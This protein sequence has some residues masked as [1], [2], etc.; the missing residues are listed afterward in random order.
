[1][2]NILEV[3]EDA[4]TRWLPWTPMWGYGIFIAISEWNV[5][6]GPRL[7]VYVKVLQFLQGSGMK[8]LIIMAIKD[9]YTKDQLTT[10]E[11]L[12]ELG[13]NQSNVS[14]CERLENLDCL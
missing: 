10:G 9:H 7:S 14:Y 11:T 8:R 3:S 5:L 6:C 1:M 4:L 2:F 13:S 12:S